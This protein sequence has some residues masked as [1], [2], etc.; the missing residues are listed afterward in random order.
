[1]SNTTVS[2]IPAP[3]ALTK[4]K[5]ENIKK[6]E[7]FSMKPPVVEADPDGGDNHKYLCKFVSNNY[8]EVKQVCT[9]DVWKR[10]EG[11]QTPGKVRDGLDS[12]LHNDFVIIQDKEGKVIDVDVIPK[13]YYTSR[14]VLPDY[15]QDKHDIIIKVNTKTGGVE[16]TQCP[17]GVTKANILKLIN[18]LDAVTAVSTG[19]TLPGGFE[20]LNVSGNQISVV[21]TARN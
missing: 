7:A 17:A 11:R 6:T 20:V 4:P 1:M 16:V 21:S 19:D 13:T 3:G 18:S 2:S 15:L 14:A 9:F 12:R 10:C 8:R 5:R